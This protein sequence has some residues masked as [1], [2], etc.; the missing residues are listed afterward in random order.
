MWRLSTGEDWYWG[1]FHND[2]MYSTPLEFELAAG[3]HVIEV[4]GYEEAVGLDRLFVTSGTDV[5]VGNDTPCH[6]PDSIGLGG[7][8]VPSCGSQGGTTCGNDACAGRPPISSYDCVVCC[9]G[10]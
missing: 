8:C 10:P 3:E 4:A 7:V 6:P 5:P 9:V 2:K 1:A